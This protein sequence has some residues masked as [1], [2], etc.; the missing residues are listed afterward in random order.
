MPD[1][2]TPARSRQQ[3]IEVFGVLSQKSQL[4]NIAIIREQ[5]GD[6]VATM[7][8]ALAGTFKSGKLPGASIVIQQPDEEPSE[9]NA[10][11][12]LIQ[13]TLVVSIIEKVMENRLQ[14][15]TG[16]LRCGYTCDE[17]KDLV[18]QSLHMRRFAGANAVWKKTVPFNDGHGGIGYLVHFRIEDSLAS[19]AR[20]ATPGITVSGLTVT[21]I[22]AS[23][24]GEAI[25]YTTDGSAPL[26]GG[27][28]VTTYTAP[29]T[30]TSGTL[31]RASTTAT[32]VEVSDF[33]Q[34]LVP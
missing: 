11:I 7:E 27:A 10:S 29:F 1:A 18:M 13:R 19:E 30:V 15:G 3:Q 32:G 21:L 6:T 26:P 17:L 12:V 34:K 28:T 22:G 4:A 23:A 2:P 16:D 9:K 33:Q 14:A 20:G 24:P 8:Q 31:V 25:L 5:R